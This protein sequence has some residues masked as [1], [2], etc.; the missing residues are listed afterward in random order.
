MLKKKAPCYGA[1][2]PNLLLLLL[3]FT[4]INFLAISVMAAAPEFYPL[5]MR[6]AAAANLK[7]IYP[8]LHP[9]HTC[10]HALYTSRI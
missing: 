10:A 5:L 4:P 7:F 8:H 1:A 6:A 2:L 9:F 3:F